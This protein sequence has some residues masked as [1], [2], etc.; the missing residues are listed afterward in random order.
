MSPSNR[1]TG[2]VVDCDDDALKEAV[3]DFCH[4]SYRV[5]QEDY[6]YLTSKE[7]IIEAIYANDYDFEV[8]SGAIYI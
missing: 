7:A 1:W 8:K 2:T 5:L 6:E 4:W 3:R